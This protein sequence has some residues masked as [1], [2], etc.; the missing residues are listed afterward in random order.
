MIAAVFLKFWGPLV[1]LTC[2]VTAHVLSAS[3]K[4]GQP[5]RQDWLTDGVGLNMNY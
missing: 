1:I 4:R 2:H 5:Q 3:S